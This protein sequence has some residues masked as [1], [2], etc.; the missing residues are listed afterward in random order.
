MLIFLLV[1]IVTNENVSPQITYPAPHSTTG[2]IIFYDFLSTIKAI[3]LKR[4]NSLNIKHVSTRAW[5]SIQ[6]SDSKQVKMVF[7]RFHNIRITHLK[8]INKKKYY[9]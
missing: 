9:K 3:N 4:I 7:W 1:K 2:R 6:M 5:H 8:R